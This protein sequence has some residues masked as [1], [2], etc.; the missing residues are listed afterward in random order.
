MLTLYSQAVGAA[1]FTISFWQSGQRTKAEREITM[2]NTTNIVRTTK[3]TA[4]LF[5]TAFVTCAVAFGAI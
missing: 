2:T 5:A 1:N 4:V 3:R